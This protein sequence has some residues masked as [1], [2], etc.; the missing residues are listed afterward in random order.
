MARLEPRPHSLSPRGLA[1]AGWTAF[2]LF[3]AVFIALAWGVSSHA[4]LVDVD[5]RVTAWLVAHRTPAV[6]AVMLAVTNLHS[7]AA[8]T[9]G[10]VLFAGILWR[11]RERYWTLTLF[12]AVAGG[13]A[14]NWML[15][16]AYERARPTFEDP[17]LVLASYSFPSGHA[18][19]AT[20][21]HGVLTAFLVSRTSRQDAR[22]LI[23]AVAIAAV[24]A[25]AFSRVYLGV[26]YLSDVLA[27]VCSSTVWLVICLSGVHA[28]VR[29]RMQR[30]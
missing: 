25:V 9:V 3:G 29:R 5:A 15:K 13:M 27:A 6:T 12:L 18:A 17:L 19:G 21:F 23:V 16:I 20:L 22:A 8:V 26:H 7:V 28:L 1:I 11:L 14:L 30:P 2:A 10:S 4:A 24:S